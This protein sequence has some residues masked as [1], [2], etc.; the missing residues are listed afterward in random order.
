MLIMNKCPVCGYD[1]LEFPPRDFTICGCCGTEFGYDDRVLSH[2][3][4]T[5]RWAEKDC[6]WFD[7]GE[8][9]PEG[10]NGNMQLIMNGLEIYLPNWSR[11]LSLS[12]QVNARVEESGI[13]FYPGNSPY[14][15][16][17]AA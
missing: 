3:E 13:R 6:P 1:R 5:R 14:S 11:E 2:G 15:A 16:R 9:K 12:F 4:L 17:I 7:P 10:W 8:P